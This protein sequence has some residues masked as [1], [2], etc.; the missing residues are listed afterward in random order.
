MYYTMLPRK[1]QGASEALIQIMD[2]AVFSC[3][4]Y[5]VE[6][7]DNGLGILSRSVQQIPQLSQGQ[8]VVGFKMFFCG[9][10]NIVE[11]IPV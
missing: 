2:I 5:L 3:N 8:R 9:F 10:Q 4:M 7:L 6:I 1:M 11:I